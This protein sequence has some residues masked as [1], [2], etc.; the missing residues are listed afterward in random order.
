MPDYLSLLP[1]V[2]AALLLV[3]AAYTDVTQFRIP[4]WICLALAVLFIAF[5][6][7]SGISPING[8]IRLGIGFSVL[9]GGMMIHSKGII[10]GGDVKLIAAL[11][12]WLE[13]QALPSFV[14]TIL[15]LGGVLALIVLVLRKLK[16]SLPEG[17]GRAGGLELLFKENGGIPY[18]V[19]ISIAGLISLWGIQVQLNL[20]G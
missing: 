15:V 12:M 10:G 4:N 8:A 14:L 17:I 5:G 1:L 9:A 6:Y 7:L 13:P 2:C 16:A 19:A 20:P 3:I 18:G 11:S